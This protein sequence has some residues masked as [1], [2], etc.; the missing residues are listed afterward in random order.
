MSL[1]LIQINSI[2]FEHVS[3]LKALEALYQSDDSNSHIFNE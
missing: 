3:I 1:K 2:S